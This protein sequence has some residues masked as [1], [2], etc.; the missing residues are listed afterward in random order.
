MR[1]DRFAP[2]YR[3]VEYAA[4]GRALERRRFAFLD[5]IAGARRILILGEG[6]GRMLR[7]LR[8]IAP[9]AEIEVIETSA[10]MIELARRRAADS[11]RVSFRLEDA[12][13]VPLPDSHYDAVVTMFFL[14]CFDESELRGL[15]QKIKRAMAP[16]AMW[17]VSEFAIPA[18]GWRRLHAMVWIRTMYRF[19]GAVSGLRVTTLPPID[20]L[21][22]E[23]N[24]QSLERAEE[25][26]G[27]IR[28]EIFRKR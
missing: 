25:R 18:Q 24:L 4:F 6:D 2:W 15:I 14:D 21:L 10:A 23:A 12:R 11:P 7:R 26:W 5:R 9:Q 17:I 13:S 16:G 20:R 19:F 27:L 1:I 8:R 3:W 22:A 28:S